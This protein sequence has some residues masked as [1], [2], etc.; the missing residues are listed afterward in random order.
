MAWFVFDAR[1]GADADVL[2]ARSSGS[3]GVILGKVPTADFTASALKPAD[4]ICGNRHSPR[5][6]LCCYNLK[7]QL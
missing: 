5:H 1:L 7:Q 3:A 6:C 4:C 2:R